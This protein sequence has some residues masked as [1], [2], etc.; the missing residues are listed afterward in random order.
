MLIEDMMS[1]TGDKMK[2][3]VTMI[4]ITDFPGLRFEENI[5]DNGRRQL[6][7]IYNMV[8]V[9]FR[10]FNVKKL[11]IIILNAIKKHI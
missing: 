7:N 1:L 4:K 3:N 2:Q 9:I 5:W 8:V 11:H 6:N 10:H